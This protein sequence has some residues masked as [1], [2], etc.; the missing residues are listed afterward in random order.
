MWG[1][2]LGRNKSRQCSKA[3]WGGLY[4]SGLVSWKAPWKE[5]NCGTWWIPSETQRKLM[6]PWAALGVLLQ[7]N[8]V[9]CTTALNNPN[10]Q[11]NIKNSVEID[12]RQ[13]KASRWK[14]AKLTDKAYLGERNT[15]KIPL[16]TEAWNNGMFF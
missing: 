6:V 9:T 4:V 16:V 12:I 10:K 13:Y 5:R 3:V 7:I 2:A 11:I 15:Q 8:C 1:H 14:D